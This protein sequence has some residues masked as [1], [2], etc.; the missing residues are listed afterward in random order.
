MSSF[1]WDIACERGTAKSCG[2]VVTVV[3]DGDGGTGGGGEDVC[4]NDI[5]SF[6]W[7]PGSET[8]PLP[9]LV[10]AFP[11]HTNLALHPKRRQYS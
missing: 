11:K 6:L 8:N 1:E 2:D 10:S 9:L 3:R 7:Q 4:E 5:S